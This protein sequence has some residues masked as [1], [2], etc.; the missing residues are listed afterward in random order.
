[1]GVERKAVERVA[2][3]ADEV[4]AAI[5][6][7]VESE[8]ERGERYAT[9]IEPLARSA[10]PYALRRSLS[11]AG[12]HAPRPQQQHFLPTVGALSRRR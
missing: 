10:N 3:E 2:G 5:V 1:V 4:G 11:L 6:R 7:E 9:L 8:T 12:R